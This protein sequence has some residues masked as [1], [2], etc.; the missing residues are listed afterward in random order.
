MTDLRKDYPDVP[1]APPTPVEQQQCA[2]CAG[3]G[4]RETHIDDRGLGHGDRCVHCGGRGI[5]WVEVDHV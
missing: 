1:L 3:T 2:Y 5:V 4:W